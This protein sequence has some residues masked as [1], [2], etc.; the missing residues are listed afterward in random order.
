MVR[1]FRLRIAVVALGNLTVLSR[2]VLA[3]N[4]SSAPRC[5]SF[6]SRLTRD[7]PHCGMGGVSVLGQYNFPCNIEHF[8]RGA[9][10]PFQALQ[11]S[12][13]G[14]I[15]RAIYPDNLFNANLTSSTQHLKAAP[16]IQGGQFGGLVLD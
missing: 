3:Q 9:T 11:G 2:T 15:G 6:T 8:F 10:P 7:Q 14:S 1:F 12:L 4:S 5:N 16:T 13:G